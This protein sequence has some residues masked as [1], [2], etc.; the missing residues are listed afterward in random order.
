MQMIKSD[1]TREWYAQQTVKNGWSRSILEIQIESGL[2]ERQAISNKK[3]TNY[4]AHLPKVQS[5]LANEILKD[6]YNYDKSMLNSS[7]SSASF[8]LTIHV[9]INPSYLISFSIVVIHFIS[10]PRDLNNI[11]RP[12]FCNSPVFFVYLLVKI[13]IPNFMFG[14]NPM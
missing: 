1:S 10:L 11:F 5:D 7:L 13:M 9:V 12:I 6:P 8:P 14:I 4:H 2:Y 3:I